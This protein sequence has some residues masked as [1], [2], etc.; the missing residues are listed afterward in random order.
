MFKKIKRRTIEKLRIVYETGY[1]HELWVYDLKV[2]DGAYTWRHYDQG[3]R[4]ID[5]QPDKIISI[6]V[7]KRKKVFYIAGKPK[8]GAGRPRKPIPMVLTQ[9]K[10]KEQSGYHA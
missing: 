5:I 1:I 4:I 2:R 10:P 3:N 6:F 7:V 9:F 8:A